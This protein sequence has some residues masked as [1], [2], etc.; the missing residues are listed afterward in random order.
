MIK[1]GIR[2]NNLPNDIEKLVLFEHIQQNYGEHRL[3]EIRLAFDMAIMEKLADSEGEVINPNSFENF[4]CAYFSKIMTG[5]RNWSA[6]EF[7]QVDK[8]EMPKQ[9]IFTQDE[10]DD[11]AREDVERQYGLFVRGIEIKN[12]L[13][14][15]PILRKDGLI[16]EKETVLEFFVKRMNACIPNI[17]IKKKP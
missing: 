16:G 1:V 2:A 7:K 13:I 6:Q 5:Y 17:Y 14:N 9:R 15:E 3:D 8:P 4:C 12:T 10:L 11:S